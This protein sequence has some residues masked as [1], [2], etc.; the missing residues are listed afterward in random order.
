MTSLGFSVV[1]HPSGE[2]IRRDSTLVRR[3]D[4][5]NADVPRVSIFPDGPDTIALVTAAAVDPGDL[6]ALAQ[7]HASRPE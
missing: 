6:R 4:S 2:P 1:C 5:K 7:H 3:V